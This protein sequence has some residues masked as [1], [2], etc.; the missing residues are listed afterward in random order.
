MDLLFLLWWLF[1]S[2]AVSTLKRM[3]QSKHLKMINAGSSLTLAAF[4]AIVLYGA[5]T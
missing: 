1:L 5:I 2:I 3:I 4:G